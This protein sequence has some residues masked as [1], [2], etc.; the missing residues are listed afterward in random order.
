MRPNSQQIDPEVNV[1][2]TESGAPAPAAPTASCIVCSDDQGPIWQCPVRVNHKCCHGCVSQ[3]IA[4]RVEDGMTVMPCPCGFADC[5]HELPQDSV[6]GLANAETARTFAALVALYKS[7][8]S[9]QCPTCHFVLKGNPKKP[10]MECTRCNTKFCFHH[11]LDH[12]DRPCKIKSV[13]AVQSLR[14]WRWRACNTRKCRVCDFRIEKN[15]G[16]AH[17]TCRCGHEICWHCGG[18]YNR[19]GQRG[20]SLTLFPSPSQYKNCCNDKKMWTKRV[21]ATCGILTVGVAGAAVAGVGLFTYYFFVVNYN[22]MMAAPRAMVRANRRRLMRRQF[23]KRSGSACAHYFPIESNGCMFCGF[24]R[25]RG[26]HHYFPLSPSA[27]DSHDILPMCTFCQKVATREEYI[28]QHPH[29]GQDQVIEVHDTEGLEQFEVDLERML[30]EIRSMGERLDSN[31][32]E[33]VVEEVYR[34]HE[35]LHQLKLRSED[36]VSV[37]ASEDGRIHGH[38]VQDN[39]SSL[40]RSH[41]GPSD[42]TFDVLNSG[43]THDVSRESMYRVS[44]K[45]P[46]HR[47]SSIYADGAVTSYQSLSTHSVI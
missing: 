10:D 46:M 28:V 16:C 26:C 14:N 25:E 6:A 5:A 30:D 38:L 41:S 19:N 29:E 32:D 20:H 43:S 15:G 7:P 1:E 17:M 34:P 33:I 8:N 13:G 4:A 47:V 23:E 40:K 35:R 42:T 11:W 36:S 45:E 31:S 37:S 44:I 22:L 18:D 21:A 27:P 2:A 39:G 12:P 9:R 24:S 3:F